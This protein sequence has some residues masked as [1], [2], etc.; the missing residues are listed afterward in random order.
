M[1][2]D[3]DSNELVN[4]QKKMSMNDNILSKVFGHFFDS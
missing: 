1:F 3:G 4:T 2:S